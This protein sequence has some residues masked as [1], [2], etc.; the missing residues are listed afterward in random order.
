MQL[1]VLI[2]TVASFNVVQSSHAALPRLFFYITY[3]CCLQHPQIHV[4]QDN[5]ARGLDAGID[6]GIRLL[7]DVGAVLDGLARG[8]P[9][10]SEAQSVAPDGHGPDDSEAQSVMDSQEVGTESGATRGVAR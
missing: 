7:A 8:G 6:H 9:D 10:E 3:L 1:L 2:I 4:R 5:D